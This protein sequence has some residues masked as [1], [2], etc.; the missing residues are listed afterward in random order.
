MMKCSKNVINNFY[1]LFRFILKMNIIPSIAWDVMCKQQIFLFRFF[2]VYPKSSELYCVYWLKIMDHEICLELWLYCNNY[3]Y[4]GSFT[5]CKNQFST[6]AFWKPGNRSRL[7][8]VRINIIII[9]TWKMKTF[10]VESFE[11]WV[12][13]SN[14]FLRHGLEWMCATIYSL[15]L[16][17]IGFPYPIFLIAYILV[18]KHFSVESFVFGWCEST[19]F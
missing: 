5:E 16:C 13:I 6:K 10:F 12:R 14:I 15:G 18:N 9:T 11:N 17:S 2:R 19:E 7:D 4:V 8:A 1:G 3:V